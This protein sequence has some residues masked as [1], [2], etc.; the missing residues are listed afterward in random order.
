MSIAVIVLMLI[1]SSGIFG[2]LSAAYQKSEIQNK[3]L[4]QKIELIEN[5]KISYNSQID[6][7]RKR[8]D[9]NTSI[10][11]SQERRLND[12]LKNDS[13]TKNIVQLQEVQSQTS[14]LI[15]KTELEISVQNKEIQKILADIKG[16]DKEVFD[17]KLQSYQQKDILTFQFVAEIFGTT[18]SKIV[19]WLIIMLIF[20]FDPLAICM[21]LAYNTIVYDKDDTTEKII[22]SLEVSKPT[23]ETIVPTETPS[24][25]KTDNSPKPESK[26]KKIFRKP[27]SRLYGR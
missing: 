16:L 24:I 14:E 1:T 5:Q 27:F 3:I 9:F 8:I 7:H 18:I 22:P 15:A 12:A 23:T 25:V 17:L 10:R 26:Y 11:D 20:V 6:Q 13:I 19:K 4:T 21:L 2:Y